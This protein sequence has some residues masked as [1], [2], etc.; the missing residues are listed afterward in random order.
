LGPY[1]PPLPDPQARQQPAPRPLPTPLAH[2]LALAAPPQAALGGGGAFIAAEDAFGFGDPLALDGL[3]VLGDRLG[4]G[5]GGGGGMGMALP[6]DGFSGPLLLGTTGELRAAMNM[7]VGPGG[8]RFGG[9]GGGG[10]GVGG[11]VYRGGAG[12]GWYAAAAPG[13]RGAAPGAA[14]GVWD[15]PA[16]MAEDEELGERMGWRGWEAGLMGRSGATPACFRRRASLPSRSKRGAAPRP[17]NTHTR[18]RAAPPPWGPR[19]HRQQLPH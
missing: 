2:A 8:G 9:G 17:T 15:E 14:A 11:V 19:P 16:A 7:G 12:G 10:G 6:G 13:R 4:G 3:D 1:N 18:A 5:G